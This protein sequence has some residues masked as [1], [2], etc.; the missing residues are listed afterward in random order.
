MKFSDMYESTEEI[1]EANPAAKI[2]PDQRMTK[3]L[4]LAVRHDRTLPRAAVARLGPRPTDEEVVKV[5]SALIDKSLATSHYGDLSAD[6]RFDQWLTRL[7]INQVN[8]FEDIN[9]EGVDAL[10]IWKTMSV[11]GILAPADQDFNRF[12]SIKQLQKAMRS[13]TYQNILNQIKNEAEFEKMKRESKEVVLIDNAR[14]LVTVPLSYGSCYLFNNSMGINANYCTG[15]SSGSHWF[16]T[17]SENGPIIMVLDK[18]HMNTANGK[19]Q[20]HSH[21][22]QISNA[23][24]DQRYDHTGNSKKFAELFPG[25]MNDI[26]NALSVHAEELKVMSREEGIAKGGWNIPDEIDN[27]KKEFA[28]AFVRY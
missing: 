2:L 15:S 11:R 8:N 21:T 27:M 1:Q 19:W 18:K 26:V 4:A 20:M 10:G 5:W 13:P 12:Q 23:N 25:L 6:G 7:Y 17:Y 14:Y 24:Q 28:P 16:P 9:G 22:Q 3:M